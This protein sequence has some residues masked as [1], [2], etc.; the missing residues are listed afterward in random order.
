MVKATNF[1]ERHD[2][3]LRWHLDATWRGRVLLEREMSSGPVI[4]RNIPSDHAPQMRPAEDDDVIET[5]PT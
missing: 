3:T 1:R 5:L 4:V 2:A